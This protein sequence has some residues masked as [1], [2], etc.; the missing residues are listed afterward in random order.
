M[1]NFTNYLLQKQPLIAKELSTEISGLPGSICPVARHVLESGGK[2]L[3]P[4]L[5]MLFAEALGRGGSEILP[6]ACALELLHSAT[7]LHDDIMD[8][9]GLRRG[10]PT[11]HRVF[12]VTET[13][14]AGDAL[15][16]LANLI[17]ARYGDVRL[18]QCLAEAT[19]RTAC[20]QMLEIANTGNIEQS[21]EEYL[22]IIQGKTA[23]MLRA[24]CLMGA[25]FAGATDSESAAAAE[26]GVSLGIAFQMVDDA[27]DFSTSKETGKPVG[28]DLREYKCTLPLFLYLQTLDET[29]RLILHGKFKNRELTEEDIAFL[30]ERIC[31]LGFDM[32]ARDIAVTHLDK[33]L[34]SIAAYPPS[35]AKN[36]LYDA[37]RFI[38]ERSM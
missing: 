29:E 27:L 4:V 38:R 10:R 31:E 37:V 18:S 13:V 35:A 34:Q 26:Y 21:F 14:L 17:V 32:R 19:M 1:C 6:L 16:A 23:W 15:L 9:A 28:G 3:R 30:T 2:R 12:G 22:D 5:V 36:A 25:I 11:A 7:L 33:A 8:H 20:G 24:S